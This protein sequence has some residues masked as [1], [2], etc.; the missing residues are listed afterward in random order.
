MLRR[1]LLA[2]ML[3]AGPAAA[4]PVAVPDCTAEVSLGGG[5][6]ADLTYRCRSSAPLTFQPAEERA[7]SFVSGL[8]VEAANGLTEAHYRFDIAGYARAVDSTSAAVLRGNS[9]LLSLGGW[10]LEPRGYDRVPVI[11]I[12][13]TTPPGMQFAT[14]LPRVGDAFRL[15]GTPLRFA[16]FSAIG[17]LSYHELP[18][19]APGSLR[20]GQ[21]RQ[22][23]VLRVAVLEGI[24]EGG[25]A[26]LLDWV[27]RTAEAESNYWQGFTTDRA[28]LALVPTSTRRGV[29]FGRAESGGGISVMVEVGSDVD[30]RR[31]FDAWVL[32][33]ELIHTGMPYIR[34]RGSWLME[35]AATYVEPIIRA[36]AGWKTE[37]EVWRE[38]LENMPNGVAGF[39]RGLSTTSGRDV[40]W[41]GAI[42]MLLADL[43]IRRE[44]QG[45]KGLE[46][47]LGG[48]LWSGLDGTQWTTVIDYGAACDRVSGT[49]AMSTL[50]DRHYNKAEAI[51]L[52]ALWKELG[53][54]LVGGRVALDD[55]AP[56]ARWRKLIVPG[57]LPPRLV[58]LPWES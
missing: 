9:A 57:I 49:H 1:T 13:V 28:L 22:S 51:D 56:S 26:D 15:A 14:G 17:A 25:I 36:R 30:R 48:I 33:H 23:G 47:C 44:T 11:D 16:G 55:S 53:V 54:S 50:I 39:S 24:S 42:F 7:R 6:E 38:W 43:A 3:A 19:A 10:L 12:R 8:K 37:E 5:L 31:L 40:Y 34:S 58:K 27:A 41:S 18:V 29:G 45:A 4:Q 20:E 32:V 2:A 35:G 52:D 46:D 21:R